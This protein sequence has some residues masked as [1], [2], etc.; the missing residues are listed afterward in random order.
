MSI[1]APGRAHFQ[2][3]A[4]FVAGHAAA[5]GWPALTYQ[6]GFI[7]VVPPG[8][9]E[10]RLEGNSLFWNADWDAVSDCTDHPVR[11]NS[12]EDAW[13]HFLA[14]ALYPDLLRADAALHPTPA[15]NRGSSMPSAVPLQYK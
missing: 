11:I 3:L 1:E 2:Q 9:A 15:T 14:L 8:G 13:R 12:G 10:R 5:A 6:A 4:D 7:T